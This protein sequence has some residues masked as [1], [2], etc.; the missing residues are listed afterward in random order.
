MSGYRLDAPAGRWIDRERAFVFRC[1]HRDVP[2]FAGDTVASALLAA[3]S[4]T[5]ARSVKLHRPRGVF[6]C[7]V[8]EPNALF[9][10]GSGAARTPNTRATDMDAAPG[11]TAV[12][13]N[14]WPSPRFDLA[15]IND[16]LAAL[17]PAGGS[18]K[19]LRWRHW[20]LCVPASRAR[21][22]LGHAA[23][24]SSGVDPDRYDEVSKQLDVLVVGGGAAGMAA[25]LAA[26]QTGR[27]VLLVDGAPRPGGWAAGAAPAL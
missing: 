19:T 8:E 11:L 10:V 12:A 1:G 27:S 4:T 14:A 3:G 26:A 7:G 15:A 13:G 5:V 9:D 25:A 22:G 23:P 18:C 24:A 21:A 17:L 16:R 6:S 20:P 2:A